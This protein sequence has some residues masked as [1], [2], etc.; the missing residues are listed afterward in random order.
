MIKGNTNLAYKLLNLRYKFAW[1]IHQAKVDPESGLPYDITVTFD[2]DRTQRELRQDMH[3]AVRI[4][5][6]TANTCGLDA[7]I[8]GQRGNIPSVYIRLE[9]RAEKTQ[10]EYDVE[11]C[12]RAA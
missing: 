11:Q 5:Q 1:H 3:R 8:D 4:A 9:K 12:I 2:N 6:L 7:V 10:T